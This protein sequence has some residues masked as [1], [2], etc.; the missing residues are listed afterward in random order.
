MKALVTMKIMLPIDVPPQG[1]PKDVEEYIELHGKFAEKDARRIMKASGISVVGTVDVELQEQFPD[2][3]WPRCISLVH[4]DDVQFIDSRFESMY[5]D[6][7]KKK[8]K[9]DG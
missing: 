2:E 4:E 9:S 7:I 8:E 1:Y 5:K 6:A 3:R